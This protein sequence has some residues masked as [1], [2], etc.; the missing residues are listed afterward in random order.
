MP[1]PRPRNLVWVCQQCPCLTSS[2]ISLDKQLEEV[3]KCFFSTHSS[4]RL[5]ICVLLQK[6]LVQI[7]QL[8]FISKINLHNHQAESS[9]IMQ[10]CIYLLCVYISVYTRCQVS[11]RTEDQFFFCLDVANFY[12]FLCLIF[13]HSHDNTSAGR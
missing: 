9:Y 3:R 7:F 5:L 2:W 11:P 6:Q 4:P 12:Y 13:R 8:A 10:A 1:Q